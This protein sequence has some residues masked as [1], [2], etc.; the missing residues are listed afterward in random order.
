MQNFF[1]KNVC[2]STKII[3]WLK[4]AQKSFWGQFQKY[5]ENILLAPSKNV[6]EIV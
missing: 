3:L 4:K 5:F 2:L 6:M 1:P